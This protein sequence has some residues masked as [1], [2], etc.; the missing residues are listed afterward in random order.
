MD[1]AARRIADLLAEIDRIADETGDPRLVRASRATRQM[2]PGR[3]AIDDAGAL[4]EAKRLLQTGVVPTRRAAC[5][6]VA[7]TH[8]LHKKPHSFVE[9]LRRKWQR[10]EIDINMQKCATKIF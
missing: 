4:A 7:K 6:K 3:P 8:G 5:M 10:E 1:E 9:R 2:S